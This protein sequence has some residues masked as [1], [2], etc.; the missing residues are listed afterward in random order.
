MLRTTTACK[1]VRK[2]RGGAQAHL[3]QTDTSEF[4]VAKAPNNPQ[5]L[6]TLINEAIGTIL[7]R[8]LGVSTP[9]PALIWVPPEI[10]TSDDFFEMGKRRVP[11]QPGTYFG[12]RYPNDPAEVA[13]YDWMPNALLSKVINISDFLGA[14]VADKWTC[15]TDRR[16]AVFCREQTGFRAY[17]I[18][19]GFI[20][21]GPDWRFYDGPLHGLCPFP[22]VYEQV[23]SLDDFEPWLHRARYFPD[24]I[25]DRAYRSIPPDWIGASRSELESLLDRLLTRRARIPA[26]LVDCRQARPGLFPNWTRLTRPMGRC[27]DTATEAIAITPD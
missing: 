12:S 23:K 25:V 21:A 8:H 27:L 3:V 1:I 11:L 19:Q 14:L 4:F 20:F 26:F 9:E 2:M 6:R 7:L 16:Q 15:N 24:S 10:V 17:M 18:D 13:V 5:H 22:A